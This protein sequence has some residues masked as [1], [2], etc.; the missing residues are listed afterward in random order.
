L[1]LCAI[2]FLT[3][4]EMMR[5]RYARYPPLE[6]SAG[7]N[8]GYSIF[9]FMSAIPILGVSAIRVIEIFTVSRSIS[10]TVCVAMISMM[11]T[12]VPPAVMS[13]F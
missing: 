1:T 6:A 11:S 5:L 13:L 3:I 10:L 12:E 8:V 7:S 9:R 2:T 4:A